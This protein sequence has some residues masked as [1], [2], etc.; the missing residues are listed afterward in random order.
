M[1]K[2]KCVIPTLGVASRS[3][4]SSSCQSRWYGTPF[5]PQY[6]SYVIP[7]LPLSPAKLGNTEIMA[8]PLAFGLCRYITYHMDCSVG[9]DV[10]TVRG[11]GHHCNAQVHSKHKIEEFH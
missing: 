3:Q 10:C 5:A 11:H 1:I 2:Y 8:S 4:L 7:I 9:E 6:E